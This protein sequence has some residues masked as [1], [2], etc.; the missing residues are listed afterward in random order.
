MYLS[1]DSEDNAPVY[2]HQRPAS[3]SSSAEHAAAGVTAARS[4]LTDSNTDAVLQSSDFA[5][6]AASV[7]ADDESASDEEAAPV[8][9]D[10][11][12]AQLKTTDDTA[13]KPLDA[14]ALRAAAAGVVEPGA[15]KVVITETFDYAG[16]AVQYVCFS[17]FDDCFS[18]LLMLF[19]GDSYG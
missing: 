18:H 3:A 1:S 16:E 2:R 5:V 13:D 10:Q 7:A 12:W 19:Q 14:A 8:T 17:L 4:L 11:M 15:N 6:T 9:V